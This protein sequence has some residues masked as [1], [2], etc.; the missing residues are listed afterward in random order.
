MDP[1]PPLPWMHIRRRRTQPGQ[2]QYSRV[3]LH[4]TWLFLPWSSSL[5][6]DLVLQ[7]QKFFDFVFA[8]CQRM[9][10]HKVQVQKVASHDFPPAEL[11]G[12]SPG[13]SIGAPLSQELSG[14][15]LDPSSFLIGE[16]LDHIL[17]SIVLHPGN[18]QLQ[19]AELGQY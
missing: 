2:Q 19:I 1:S 13:K 14:F 18:F 5:S 11:P 16:T 10:G 6:G 4:K 7:I 15:Y 3:H 12:E 8:V 17:C 9:F